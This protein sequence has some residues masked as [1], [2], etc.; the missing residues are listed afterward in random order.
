MIEVCN[1]SRNYS[2]YDSDSGISL[3]RKKRK[4]VALDNISFKVKVGDVIG[5]L[6][7][8]GAGK[9]TLI[10]ILCGIIAPS[11][12]TVIVDNKYIP[13]AKKNEY[14]KRI[15]LISGNKTQLNYDLSAKDN[16]YF[17]GALYGISRKDIDREVRKNAEKLGCQHMLDRQI[18][19]MSFGERLKMEIVGALIHNPEYIF[20]D[21]PT[22]G[23]DVKTQISL[24]KFIKELG[25]ERKTIFITSH[26]LEDISEVCKKLIY[27]EGGKLSF[28]GNLHQFCE[29]YSS[30][31][32]VNIRFNDE[33]IEDIVEFIRKKE[34][35]KDIVKEGN[36]ISFEVNK[37]NAIIEIK[38]ILDEFEMRIVSL[39]SR[40]K[41]IKEILIS[42]M[43]E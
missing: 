12:G 11:S 14:L 20:L 4:I 6:G 9:S 33:H 32:Q 28:F 30:S 40:E 2:V 39:E 23:L 27:I 13:F 29:K 24:R 21:E 10:K 42:R 43:I 41:D 36:Y 16:F 15:T 17:L 31:V 34:K 3:F 7:A 5:I 18:R 22:I 37:A 25:N 19:K 1:V 26:N 38:S 35:I 8:N